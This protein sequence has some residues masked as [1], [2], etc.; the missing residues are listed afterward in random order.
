MMGSLVMLYVSSSNYDAAGDVLRGPS[1]QTA[2]ILNRLPG[3]DGR[4]LLF[5]MANEATRSYGAAWELVQLAIGLPAAF[6]LF[7]E[8]RTR[9]YSIGVGLM[10][11][12]VLFE[13]FVLLPQLDWLGRTADFVSWK[14]T[15]TPRDQYWNLRAVFL[16]IEVLKLLVGAGVSGAL[17]TVRSRS[18]VTRPPE[19]ET[20]SEE[21]RAARPT[22]VRRRRSSG[23]HTPRS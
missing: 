13:Y 8:R 22:P 20:K 15:S 3:E 4:M 11:L 23:Q 9:F 6:L 1:A 19:S 10:L 7:L 14:V 12:V 21:L 5:H 18:Q 17:L 2:R 16:G